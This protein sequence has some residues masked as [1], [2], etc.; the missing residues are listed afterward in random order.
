MADKTGEAWRGDVDKYN[1]WEDL[2]LTLGMYSTSPLRTIIQKKREAK[3]A[4]QC[5]SHL[6]CI[7]DWLARTYQI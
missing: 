4:K 5:C 2:I 6:N 7:P 1:C 3:A